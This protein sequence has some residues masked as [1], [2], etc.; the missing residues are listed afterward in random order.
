M[1]T[2]SPCGARTMTHSTR[3]SGGVWYRSSKASGGEDLQIEEPVACRDCSSFHFHSTLARVLR[4]ALIGDEV[5]QVGESREKRLLAPFGVMEAFHREQLPL[6]GI[7]GLIQQ[8]TGHG[9]LRVCQHRIPPSFLLLEPA[10][11]TRAIGRPHGGG[12][13]V[14]KVA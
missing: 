10:S 11:H 14:D 13:A 6:D 7:M 9:H 4:P 2:G 8:G 5:V 1:W 3:F 12:D